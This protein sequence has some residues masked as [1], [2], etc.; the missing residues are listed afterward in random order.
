MGLTIGISNKFLVLLLLQVRWPYFE[1]CCFRI[2]VFF[3]CWVHTG[4]T[5][6]L[7]NITHTHVPFRQ[8]ESESLRSEP[9]IWVLKSGMGNQSPEPMLIPVF[10]ETV[11][12]TRE[13]L[14]KMQ[15]L[16][17]LL[18]GGAQGFAFWTSSQVKLL[19]LLC[20]AHFENQELEM[21][22]PSSFSCRCGVCVS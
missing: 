4:V 10:L 3:Q 13:D 12:C 18:W 9:G 11:T 7:L 14:L 16:V 15:T 5:W 17:Q 2:A 21:L 6:G 20:G 1:N 8:T 22:S 19:L